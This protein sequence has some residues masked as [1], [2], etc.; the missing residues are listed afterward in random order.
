M[1]SFFVPSI[2]I[3]GSKLHHL[4]GGLICR[5]YFIVESMLTLIVS[6]FPAAIFTVNSAGL[7]LTSSLTFLDDL[8]AAKISIPSINSRIVMMSKGMG[9]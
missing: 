7:I 4:E 5:T 3:S 6:F 2:T 1:E 8:K 9:F